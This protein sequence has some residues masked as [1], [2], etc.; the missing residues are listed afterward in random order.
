MWAEPPG[1]KYEKEGW[2]NIMYWGFYGSLVL[3]VV[4]YAFKPDTG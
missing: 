2:E 1:H 3:A 4:G